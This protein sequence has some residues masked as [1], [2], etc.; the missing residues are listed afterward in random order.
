MCKVSPQM[1]NAHVDRDRFWEVLD[2]A[3]AGVDD[4]DRVPAAL[5][6]VL[7][8]RPLAELVAFREVQDEL[9]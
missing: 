8:G 1:Q 7:R 9:F 4:A 6:E 2:D 3:R 5:V